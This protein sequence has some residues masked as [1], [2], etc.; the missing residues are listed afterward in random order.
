MSGKDDPY[1]RAAFP[2]Q[3][4]KQWDSELLAFYKAAIKLRH[5]NPCLRTGAF[6]ILHARKGIFAIG[7]SLGDQRI[8]AI[9]NR[10]KKSQTVTIDVSDFS[11]NGGEFKA[12][13]GKGQSYTVKNNRLS[14]VAIPGREA[15]VLLG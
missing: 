11:K 2:W 1:C 8:I 14:S 10:R 6:K 9:F 5:Q 7:R 3:D 12:V 15:I 4:K 13:W